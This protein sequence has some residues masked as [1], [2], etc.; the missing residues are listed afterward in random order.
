VQRQVC[1]GGFRDS[2]RVAS[3]SPE[4]WRD[5]VTMNRNHVA[6]AV[7]DFRGMLDR[8]VTLLERNDPAEID[9]FFRSA[10]EQRDGWSAQCLP[11]S[12]E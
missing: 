7:K 12:P 5:I 9:A 11:N 4:M 8:F 2:T 1:A 3:G 6:A 10:K